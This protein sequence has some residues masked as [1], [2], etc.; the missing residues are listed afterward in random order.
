MRAAECGT[1][2]QP[3][4]TE[5]RTE[6]VMSNEPLPPST[7][8]VDEDP[9]DRLDSWKDIAAYL[10]RDVSTV[11]RWEKREGMPVH[12]HVHEK[13]GSVYAYRAELDAW[14]R[15]RGVRLR[16]GDDPLVDVATSEIPSDI[17]TS[18]MPT[19]GAPTAPRR[20]H[21]IAAM[22]AGALALLVTIA[23]VI[24][25]TTRPSTTDNASTADTASTTDNARELLLRAK[26]LGVRTTDADT[27]HAIALIERAI[28]IEPSSAS[29]YAALASAYVTRLAYVTP[30]ETTGLEEKAFAAAE[31][32][33]ALDPKVP[34]AYVARGD[35]LWTHA[36]R[37]AHDRAVRE[38]R[39][40][41]SLNPD[42]DEIH[43]RLARV[44][45]H[46]GF[47]DEALQHAERALAINPTN[48]QALNSRAQALLWM[49][50]DEE[51]LSILRSM[52]GPV[53]P[54]LVEANISY[55]LIHLGRHDD[56]WTNLRQALRT[57]PDDPTG[58]LRGIE[59]ML[60]AESSPP[61]A[62]T[63]IDSIAN[64]RMKAANPSH[65]AAYF[66]ACAFARMRNAEE[67]VRW[68]TDA[69]ATGFPC[70][71][72]F[73]RDPH[74]D[75]IRHDPRFQ[76]FMADMRKRSASL[77]KDLFPASTSAQ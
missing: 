34:E 21:A 59:A 42:S 36:Q 70:Y 57:Y 24:S 26:Y 53:L 49:G 40:A 19:S 48:A 5:A 64:G 17:P 66:A 76:T 52:P 39:R 65:H 28:A 50:R 31:R 75:P 62:R 30:D 12:R 71:A 35:L 20:S 22:V 29:G 16:A 68:L 18:D 14:S 56:A 61:A 60:R 37:F 67:A 54:E 4:R 27:R 43:R 10:R 25:V 15:S 46:V 32:A 63:L 23:V 44:Y 41:L 72:L 11:Q 7:P 6:P 1:L 45:V 58:T 9:S 73:T 33:L 8:S 3:P 2:P 55:A 77:R 47:F 51:A 13:L 69:A 38:F 74:L